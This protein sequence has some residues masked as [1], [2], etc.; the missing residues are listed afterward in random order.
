MVVF[1]A[2][3]GPKKPSHLTGADGQVRPSSARVGPK[4]LRRPATV[5]TSAAFYQCH[6]GL[7]HLPVPFDRAAVPAHW[8]TEL[9]SCAGR[10]RA[11]SPRGSG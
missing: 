1:P 7:G 5:M 6:P 10:R 3:L 9:L 8:G 11:G 2:P 4:L